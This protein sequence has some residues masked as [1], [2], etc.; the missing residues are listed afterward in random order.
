MR[1]SMKLRQLHK[2]IGISIENI[3]LTNIDEITFKKIM[4]EIFNYCFS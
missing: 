4:D 3:N 1:A 2:N